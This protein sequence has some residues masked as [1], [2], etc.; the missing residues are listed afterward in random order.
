MGKTNKKGIVFCKKEHGKL[1]FRK[2]LFYQL[3][4]K[5]IAG[6]PKYL[7]MGDDERWHILSVKTFRQHFSFSKLEDE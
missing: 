1:P 6:T 5:L 7:V 3:K 2:G 4:K